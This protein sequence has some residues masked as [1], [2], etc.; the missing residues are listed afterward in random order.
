MGLCGASHVGSLPSGRSR[1]N[2]ARDIEAAKGDD[3]I[4]RALIEVRVVVWVAQE[5]R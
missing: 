5:G 3:R 2:K 1:G 4:Q